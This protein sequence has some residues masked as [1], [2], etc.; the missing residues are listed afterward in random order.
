MQSCDFKYRQVL[1][2]H[3]IKSKLKMCCEIKTV[4]WKPT[5]LTAL[6]FLLQKNVCLEGNEKKPKSA[7]IWK[8]TKKIWNSTKNIGAVF[9]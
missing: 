5:A 8:K 4:F 7:K 1:L 2:Q 3:S 9:L 6:I